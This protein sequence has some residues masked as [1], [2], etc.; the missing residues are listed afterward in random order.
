MGET[1]KPAK[2]ICS[3]CGREIPAG[4]NVCPSCGNVF[5]KE[6][7]DWDWKLVSKAAKIADDEE[8]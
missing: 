8:E 2:K 5:S 4:E 1:D 3:L 7:G 6:R